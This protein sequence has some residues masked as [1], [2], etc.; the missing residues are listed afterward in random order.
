MLLIISGAALVILVL[1]AHSVFRFEQLLRR[2]SEQS[3][4]ELLKALTDVL[5]NTLRQMDAVHA[6]GERAHSDDDAQPPFEVLTIPR[7]EIGEG[8]STEL[9]LFVERPM[10]LMKLVFR[11][12]DSLRVVTLESLKIN[13]VEM[14]TYPTRLSTFTELS[15]S[16][17]Y[18]FAGLGM[19]VESGDDIVMRFRNHGPRCEFNGFM[20]GRAEPTLDVGRPAPTYAETE[21]ELVMSLAFAIE[22]PCGAGAIEFARRLLNFGRGVRPEARTKAI[23]LMRSWDGALRTYSSTIPSA[24]NSEVQ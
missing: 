12:D 4:T 16:G 6:A 11:G 9:R 15:A 8:G 19:V 1:V 14:L 17:E 3:K 23:E 7:V 18:G 10:S 13:D 20:A 5:L 2:K 22:D 21:N 24:S